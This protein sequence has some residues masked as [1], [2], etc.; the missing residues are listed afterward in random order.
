MPML[1][2]ACALEGRARGSPCRTVLVL[3]SHVR[4]HAFSV[5]KVTGTRLFS[6]M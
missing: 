5:L 2:P 4:S 1:K 6:A 3:L